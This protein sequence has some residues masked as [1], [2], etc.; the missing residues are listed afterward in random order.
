ME[1]EGTQPSILV[2]VGSRKFL[3]VL[4]PVLI[5]KNVI[6]FFAVLCTEYTK[7]VVFLTK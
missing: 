3:S 1:L 7:Y 5:L 4:F 6:Y 2:K